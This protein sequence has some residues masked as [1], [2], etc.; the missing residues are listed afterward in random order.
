MPS[1]SNPL[2]RVKRAASSKR[3]ADQEYRAALLAA[4]NLGASY[5]ELAKLAGTSRQAVRQLIE[6][7]L[8]GS[9]TEPTNKA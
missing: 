3:R 5:A 2:A 4:F 7:A 8:T 6:R 1:P 9:P